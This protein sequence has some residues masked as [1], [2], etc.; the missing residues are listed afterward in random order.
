MSR[1]SVPFVGLV[2]ILLI[3]GL[4]GCSNSTE[5]QNDYEEFMTA[6]NAYNSVPFSGSL[7]VAKGDD[8]IFSEGYGLADVET[9]R[10]NDDE[11][12]YAIGSI[13]KSMT[14]VAILQLQEKGFLSVEDDISMYLEGGKAGEK[15]TIHQLL[16]HTAG[17]QR[18]GLFYRSGHLDLSED[19]DFILNSDRLKQPGESFSYSNAGYQLLAAIIELVSGQSYNDYLQEHIFEAV[20]MTLSKGGTDANYSPGQSIGYNI[21]GDSVLRLGIYDL[22]NV[23]GSG[24]VYSSVHDL[25]HYA[26]GLLHGKL[27]N[28]KSLKMS[29][30][31][32][33]GT[34]EDGYGYGWFTEMHDHHRVLEHSGD[35]GGG[36]YVS[37]IIIY[38]DEEQCLILLTNNA[39][40]TAL[41]IV[42]QTFECIIEGKDYV[43]PK[44]PIQDYPSE[45]IIANYLGIYDFGHGILIEVIE[46][47][48]ALYTTADDGKWHRLVPVGDD[49]Y[50][51]DGYEWV[52]VI[53]LESQE[54]GESIMRIQNISSILE[55][56][57]VESPES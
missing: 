1:L 47:D 2:L 39:D 57:K 12:I 32:H 35:I 20:G 15:I 43:L 14:A 33:W 10:A 49:I 18:E 46:K 41:E 22:S 31:P 3:V 48:N 42:S 50:Q 52:E 51:Y 21:S 53:F 25:H 4:T 37:R 5:E 27:L 34:L 55:G 44:A 16:T 56:M 40:T 7:L 29:T 13:T 11:S 54:N 38:P 45:G 28:G 19:V 9:K 36:G 23:I 26:M 6:F 30:I 8:V 17:L 24:N